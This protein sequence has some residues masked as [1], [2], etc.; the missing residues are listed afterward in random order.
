MI[1]R[2]FT[3]N[4]PQVVNIGMIRGARK[5]S[6]RW[7]S[8]DRFS[9]IDKLVEEKK[10]HYL[11]IPELMDDKVK[12]HTFHVVI[13]FHFHFVTFANLQEAALKKWLI[14]EGDSFRAGDAIC[15]LAYPC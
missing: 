5:F 8:L 15:E 1:R 3:R 12:H 13:F 9:G 2:V 14:K 6:I 4:I 11:K 10:L 7:N